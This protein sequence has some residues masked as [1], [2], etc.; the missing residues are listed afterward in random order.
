[1]S[2]LIYL[3]ARLC[4][5][6][7]ASQY[8]SDG[9]VGCLE[10]SNTAEITLA[11]Q[12]KK[13]LLIQFLNWIDL[14]FRQ[15]VTRASSL[16]GWSLLVAV[17][18]SLKSHLVLLPSLLSQKFFSHSFLS[19]CPALN[20]SEFWLHCHF[21]AALPLLHLFILLISLGLVSWLLELSSVHPF[22]CI[23]PLFRG[24]GGI[25]QTSD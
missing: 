22:G 12:K 11:K 4:L 10:S 23:F 6:L 1:M 2:G 24:F 16:V 21:S 25:S 8:V 18:H 14:I 5:S 17:K 3:C 7:R 15:I 20:C 19:H 13:W 9:V